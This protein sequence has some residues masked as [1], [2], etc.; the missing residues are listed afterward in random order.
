VVK[1]FG[2]MCRRRV[3][4]LRGEMLEEMRRERPQALLVDLR[5][6]LVA[7]APAEWED[8]AEGPAEGA[9]APLSVFV[10]G[11][12][13]LEA[14][15]AFRDR[16]ARRGLLRPIATSL[17]AAEAWA[18]SMLTIPGAVPLPEEPLPA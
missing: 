14:A 8:L 7:L 4:Q 17:A 5:S 11:A 13:Y 10:V 15:F 3:D 18:T 1:V 9:H 12:G 16:M 2:V 6:A